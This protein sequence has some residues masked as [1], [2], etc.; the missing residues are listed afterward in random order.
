MRRRSKQREV[1]LNLLKRT[2]SHPSAEW[3][4]TEVRKE[5]PNISLGTVYR[6]IKLLQ[7]MGEVSEISCEGDECRFDG[8]T[9]LHYHITCQRCG[10]IMDLDGIVLQS[11]EERVAAATGFKI[12][13]HCVGFKGVCP[14]CLEQSSPERY[15]YKVRLY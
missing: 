13:N 15:K 7:S 8:N 3:V 11:L 2:K 14:D 4:Y 6:N 12:T 5:I 9:I 10:K 1:I